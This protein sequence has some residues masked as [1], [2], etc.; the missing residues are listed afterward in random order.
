MIAGESR[1]EAIIPLPDGRRVPVQ[2]LNG[3]GGIIYQ[4]IN[5]STIDAKSFDDRWRGSA[6][7]NRRELGEM[8]MQEY[9]NRP[10]LRR[11]YA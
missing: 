5:I 11:K 4:T 10:S 1:A 3:G 7:K 2:L 9:Q 6:H 8:A